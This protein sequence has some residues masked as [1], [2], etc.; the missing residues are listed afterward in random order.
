MQRNKHRCFKMS[1]CCEAF[2]CGALGTAQSC[3]QKCQRSPWLTFAVRLVYLQS[4]PF[5][6]FDIEAFPLSND[7]YPF[8]EYQLIHFYSVLDLLPRSDQRPLVVT[9]KVCLAET[10]RIALVLSSLVCHTA[11]SGVVRHLLAYFDRQ[12]RQ[13]SNRFANTEDLIDSLR[14]GRQ[15]R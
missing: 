7:Q 3:L 6:L 14:P 2:V 11:T 5:F 4:P 13:C 1:L 12:T 10:S 15:C 9:D 8:R